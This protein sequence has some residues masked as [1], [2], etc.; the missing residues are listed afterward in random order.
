[1]RVSLGLPIHLAPRGLSLAYSR[2]CHVIALVFLVIVIVSDI[3]VQVVADAPAAWIA[4]LPMIVALWLVDRRPTWYFTLLYLAVGTT[5]I[6]THSWLLLSSGSAHATDDL[7]LSMPKMALILVGGVAAGALPAILWGLLA[8]VLAEAATILPALEAGALVHFDG[9]SVVA[10]ALVTAVLGAIGVNRHRVRIAGPNL[11]RAA[12]EEHFAHVRHRMEVKAAALLHDTVLTHL[13]ALASAPVGALHDEL[14]GQISRD[15]ELVAGEE[16]LVDVGEGVEE[17]STGWR[18]SLL[19]GVIDD[20]RLLGLTVEVSGDREAL[21]RLS[22]GRSTAVALAAKQCLVNV[23]KHAG[24]RMSTEVPRPG[25]DQTC[26]VPCTS[27]MRVCT[28]WRSPS[29]SEPAAETSNPRP[30][31]MIMTE[32]SASEP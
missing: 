14:R 15:L 25:V 26:T 1:M 12:R 28:E 3:T 5:G 7:V 2:A 8:F 27:S 30:V 31:S 19:A 29:R 32:T 6:A 18:A 17:T 22:S 4:L 9:S 21:D 13:A 16:W 11:H 10:V 20:V 24:T 23:V